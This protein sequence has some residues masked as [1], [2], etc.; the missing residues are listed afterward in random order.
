MPLFFV[1]SGFVIHY[2]YGASFRIASLN[3]TVDFFIARFARLYPL[4]L[5]LLIFYLFNYRLLPGILTHNFDIAILPRYLLLWQSWLLEYRGTTWFGHL[6]LPPAWSIS[7]EVFF[8]ALYPLIGPNLVDIKSSRKL[9]LFFAV[10]VSSFWLMDVLCYWNFDALRVWGNETFHIDADPQNALL[11]WLLNTGP[12]G[13]LFEFMTGAVAAQAL[14]VLH[15]YEPSVG[16]HR[17]GVTAL[18]ATVLLA[19]ALYILT[20][21]NSLIAFMG[22]YPGGLAPLFAIIIFCASRYESG[23]SR[24]LGSTPMLKL[25]DASYSIYLI[26]L[27]TLQLFSL[28]VAFPPSRANYVVWLLTML[29]AIFFTIIL[30][31]GLYQVFEAPARTFLR[32]RLHACKAK[33]FGVQ[34]RAKRFS[35]VHC[36]VVGVILSALFVFWNW[37]KTSIIEVFDATY[38]ESCKNVSPPAPALNIFKR[39]NATDTVKQLCAGKDTCSFQVN[40]NRIGDPVPGCAKDF[41]ITYSCRSNSTPTSQTVKAEAHGQTVVI[42]CSSKGAK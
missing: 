26:H 31:L 11:G 20:Q 39:G 30:S 9:I 1:L 42:D 8:Y 35:A 32:R 7:V 2:N 5:L 24:L 19:L 34:I 17:A 15:P 38:G 36:T 14:I 27:F 29:G 4:Y 37:P 33:I 22:T 25:G 28:I 10:L 3:A 40:V 41:Q 21:H 13:R 6:L 16:E 12:I 23:L 18:Y